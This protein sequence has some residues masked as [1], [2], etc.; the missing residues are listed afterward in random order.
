MK[1]ENVSVLIVMMIYAT[2][3]FSALVRLRDLPHGKLLYLMALLMPWVSDTFAYFSGRF[4]GWH[5]LIP[6]VSPKRRSKGQSEQ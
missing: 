5:K 1:F 6:E 2:F 4:F 3:G